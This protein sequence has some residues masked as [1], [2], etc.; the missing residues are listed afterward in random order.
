MV[1]IFNRKRLD[2]RKESVMLNKIHEIQF[3]CYIQGDSRKRVNI[4]IPHI[5][6]VKDSVK[7]SKFEYF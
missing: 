3:L 2:K 5:T 4:A 7:W 6:I 1:N